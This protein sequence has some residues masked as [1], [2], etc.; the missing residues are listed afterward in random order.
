MGIPN[1][2]IYRCDRS[3]LTSVATRLGGALIAAKKCLV[4][5]IV[6]PSSN[7]IESVYVKIS[8]QTLTI[9]FVNVY[10]PP[11]SSVNI[12][13]DFIAA[14]EDVIQK[15]DFSMIYIS[16]DFN[17]P[18]IYW[19]NDEFGSRP[20]GVMTDVVECVSNFSAFLNFYQI[21]NIPNANGGFLDLIFTRNIT[22]V[23]CVDVPL[24]KCDKYHPALCFYVKC[25]SI[26]F[27]DFDYFYYDFNNANYILINDFLGYINWDWLTNTMDVNQAIH[28]FYDIIYFCIDL[29][30]PKKKCKNK[31]FPNSYSMELKNAILRKKQAHKKFKQTNT[32]SDYMLF[33]GIR[34][35]CKIL[36][37]KSKKENIS[38]IESNMTDSKQ[39]WSYVHSKYKYYDLPNSMKYGDIESGDSKVIA[40]LFKKHFCRCYD[41]GDCNILNVN[42]NYKKTIDI[43]NCDVSI[44]DVFNKIEKLNLKLSCG[45]DDISP[46]FVYNCRFILSSVLC[47]I[48]NLSLQRGIFPH[49]WKKSYIT[50]IFKSGNRS[51][52]ENYRPISKISIFSKVF[53][54]IIADR[55]QFPIKSIIMPEQHGFV[56]SRSTTTNLMILEEYILDAFGE[57]LQVDVVYT[58]FSKAFDRV[59]IKL[60]IQKLKALGIR[61]SLYEWLRSY[62][63]DRRQ[64][65][66]IKNFLSEEIFVK[67]GVP[68]G[69]HLSTILFNCFIND[70]SVCFVDCPILLYADDLKIYRIVRDVRDCIKIQNNL[71]SFSQWCTDNGLLLN[72][73]KCRVMRFY[74]NSHP[75]FYNYSINN[76][77][78]E[79]TKMFKDL[80]VLFDPTL[81]FKAH[82][83]FICNK[84]LKLLGFIKRSLSDFNNINCFKNV[85]CSL[86]R[87]VLEYSSSVWS[88][89]YKCH[90]DNIERVQKKFLRFIAFKLKIPSQD[91]VYFE[92]LKLLNIPTLENRREILDLFFLF[93]VV[94]G[95]IDSPQLLEK[96]DFRIP[97]RNTRCKDI[98]YLKCH[99][100]NYCHNKPI[101]RLINTGNKAQIDFFSTSLSTFKKKVKIIYNN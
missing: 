20:V 29:F 49:E 55:I 76:S 5:A 2:Y 14:T 32:I 70:V 17:L 8:L 64:A 90:I 62:S 39:F 85:Y 52:I 95:L 31:K 26:N 59:N 19:E 45:P 28:C 57:G 56:S 21:N 88:P 93:K 53:E 86:V 40:N 36:A 92:I 89:F 97:K 30:I 46:I 96:V 42:L 13:E 81:S 27:Q 35:E 48:F 33:S 41:D 69:G 15:D 12:Y 83:D 50:P 3:S 9:L 71:N 77:S 34:R 66:K 73:E 54:S 87:S 80:G 84:A 67:S 38:S 24:L 91:I 79:P 43:N 37:E 72:I 16:G 7:N 18:N 11:S 99:N 68:Q 22:N 47:N 94:N 74:R 10:I 63:T 1:Y 78:L 51:L 44:L 61:G 100:T 65:V 75:I 98:F 23:E 25:D 4:S 6:T 58:D 82:Y 101:Q 60:L